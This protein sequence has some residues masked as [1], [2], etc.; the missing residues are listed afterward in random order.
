MNKFFTTS[1]L[2]TALCAHCSYAD[3]IDGKYGK[4]QVFYSQPTPPLPIAGQEFQLY[5]FTQ[6][7]ADNNSVYDI[8]GGYVGFFYTNDNNKPIG[9][10]LYVNGNTQTISPSGNIFG[11]EYDG[12]LYISGADQNG[13]ITGT[14]TKTFISNSEGFKYG[15]STSY[16]PTKNGAASLAD[17]HA[18]RATPRILGEGEKIILLTINPKF[19]ETVTAQNNKKAYGIAAVL[20]SSIAFLDDDAKGALDD[21]DGSHNS[22]AISKATDQLLPVFAGSSGYSILDIKEEAYHAVKS[23]NSIQ[24]S[25][26]QNGKELWVEPLYTTSKQNDQDN[27]PGHDMKAGGFICGFDTKL[28]EK[29]LVGSALSYTTANINSND[30]KDKLDADIYDIMLYGSYAFTPNNEISLTSSFASIKNKSSRSISIASLKR[31]ASA[32]YNGFAMSVGA[33]FTNKTNIKKNIDVKVGV[34]IDYHNLKN[35]EYTET[36]A[37]SLN[38]KTNAQSIDRFI[39]S[40]AV[41]GCYGFSENLSLEASL[42]IACNVFSGQSNVTSAF[43]EINNTEF[44]TEGLMHPSLCAKTGLSMAYKCNNSI[45]LSIGYSGGIW[46][47]DLTE[48]TISFRASFK[49]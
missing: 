11:L 40:L 16:I 22:K 48:H 46:S 45:D 41:G 20:D 8:A 38:L 27:A 14:G 49:L 25:Y 18:Y 2:I 5:N 35:D 33:N 43:S 4:N 37:N 17:L 36:G 12:F 44:K 1:L 19:L 34:G 30:A 7:Y 24:K 6:A 21:V 13:A 26:A 9:I 29:I 23:R 3:I 39:P 10:K 31:T 42:G 28:S 47:G 15:N 32:D